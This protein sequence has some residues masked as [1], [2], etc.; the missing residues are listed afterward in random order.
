MGMKPRR[1]ASKPEALL[2]DAESILRMARLTS[3]RPFVVYVY[4]PAAM[5]DLG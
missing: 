2:A 1:R 5:G 4:L 3:R